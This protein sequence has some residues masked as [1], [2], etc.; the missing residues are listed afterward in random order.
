MADTFN[1]ENLFGSS[2]YRVEGQGLKVDR[3]EFG[4]PGDDGSFLVNHGVRQRRYRIVG[5]LEAVSVESLAA[6]IRAIEEYI[7]D[8]GEYT[9]VD[10]LGQSYPSVVLLDFVPKG[11]RELTTAGTWRLEYEVPFVQLDPFA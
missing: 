3:H 5:V 11:P 7:A 6:G 4:F 10:S 8:G 1:G 2:G 9:L